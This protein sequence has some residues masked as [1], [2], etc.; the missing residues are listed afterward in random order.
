LVLST[1][2]SHITDPGTLQLL[3]SGIEYKVRHKG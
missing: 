1:N 2:V 3:L